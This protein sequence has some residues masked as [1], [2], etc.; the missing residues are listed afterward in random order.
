[1]PGAVLVASWR[2]QLRL[3]LL[4]MMM[5][6]FLG[7]GQA[8]AGGSGEPEAPLLQLD[9]GRLSWTA[10]SLKGGKLLVSVSADVSL[11]HVAPSMLVDALQPPVRGQAISVAGQPV[12]L[13]D[14]HSLAMGKD[15]N[16]RLWF[17]GRDVA[18]LQRT[19]VESTRGDERY[20]LYRFAREGISIV[21]RKPMKG[22]AQ[23]Q[24]EQWRDVKRS[25]APYPP[26]I[27]DGMV[28]S[29]PAVLLYLAS[30]AEFEEPGDEIRLLAYFDDMVQII[31]MHYE[32]EEEVSAD[33]KVRG[34]G[35]GLQ[36][37]GRRQV[38][39]LGLASR[40]L[41]TRQ[42]NASLRI[43]GLGGKLKILVDRQL[44]VP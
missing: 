32:G 39:R 3:L 19:R 13:I 20:K 18:A 4:L 35:G 2:R 37:R 31:T 42:G 38:L 8:A 40:P 24:P 15:L 43:S 5:A 25:F 28:V 14:L 9:D 44:R 27:P 26:G 21:R 22:E 36:I 17:R 10:L 6:S 30:V 1:M 29:D 12:L 33:F 16:T 7:A 34:P 11:R 41:D 23:Q